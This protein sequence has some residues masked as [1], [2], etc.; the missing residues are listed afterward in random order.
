MQLKEFGNTRTN[1][2]GM[3]I[4][5]LIDICFRNE[6]K[7][8]YSLNIKFNSSASI[9]FQTVRSKVDWL[10]LS[11]RLFNDAFLTTLLSKLFP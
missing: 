4:V 6:T 2:Y 5:Y 8:H 3:S 1:I 9:H 10:D 7:I 11:A